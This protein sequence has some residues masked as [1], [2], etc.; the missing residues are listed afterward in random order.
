MEK[1][2]RIK[3]LGEGNFGKVF[4]SRCNA[5]GSLVCI[6]MIRVKGIPKKE[7]E[8]CRTE[9]KLMQKLQHPNIC[10]YKESF[11]VNDKST[12]AIVMQ[13]CD[14]GDLANEIS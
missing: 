8:A 10:G 6:K 7:R 3:A 11:L 2:S 12:L 13:Y 5:D 1:Y 4:L 14:S 9:V